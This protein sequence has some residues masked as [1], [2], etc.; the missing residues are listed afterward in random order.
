MRYTRRHPARKLHRLLDRPI[1]VRILRLK[2]KQTAITIRGILDYESGQYV[3]K[4]PIMPLSIQP[5]DRFVIATQ[6][7]INV[8][9][10]DS[11]SARGRAGFVCIE[12]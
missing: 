9:V 11:S 2:R 10:H 3:L 8:L 1:Q 7:V 12:R 4:Y 6:Y 5:T